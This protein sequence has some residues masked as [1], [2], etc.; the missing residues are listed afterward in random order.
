VKSATIAVGI[1]IAA[2]RRGLTF[3]TIQRSEIYPKPAK[4]ADHDDGRYDAW[5]DVGWA[6]GLVWLLGIIVL[7]LAAAALIKYLRS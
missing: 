6:M 7:I 2:S 1:L 4:K 3:R 5:N